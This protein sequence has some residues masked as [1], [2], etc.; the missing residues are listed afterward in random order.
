MMNKTIILLT[1]AA[2]LG[3]ASAG[4]GAE[5]FLYGT[6]E[7]D[8]GNTY[9]GFLRWGSEEAFWDDHFNSTKEKL[10]YADRVPE[11][12]RERRQ[13]D[14]FGFTIGW[15]ADA[16]GGRSLTLRFGDIREIE[17]SGGDRARVTL[18][19]GRVLDLDGG[20]ND[21]GA[22]ITV[23]DESLGEVKL[24]WR[25][26]GRITFSAAPA[27]ATPP[28]A[29]LYGTL[30][31]FHQTYRGH[32][33]WDLQECLSTD[34]LDGE[35]ADGDVSIEMGKIRT[36][37]KRS[38]RGVYVDLW[39]G[40][41]LSLSGTNDV[42]SSNDGIF[43]ED[44]RFGRVEVGWDEFEKLELERTDSSGRGYDDYPPARALTGT[45][46]DTSGSRTT[47]RIVFDLDESETWEMLDGDLDDVDYSIPFDRIAAIEPRS[48]DSS[49]VVL[50]D[51]SELILE[52]SQDVSERNDGVVVVPL[53]GRETFIAWRRIERIEFD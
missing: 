48:R 42:N 35:T 23:Q 24:K 34:E 39:D 37:E 3:A 8:N 10:E 6:V 52:D 14:L 17:P 32:I 53:E 18:K 31:T 11:E 50:R 20:S 26:I 27:G 33:Q 47:G 41:R 9:R 2:L 40:R 19:N 36:I 12:E 25:D 43:V 16:T 38:R 5:G 1:T 45:V 15:R 49:L 44:E 29:R 22:T 7:S 28:A 46:I 21:M 30:T 13:I 51:G 4:A